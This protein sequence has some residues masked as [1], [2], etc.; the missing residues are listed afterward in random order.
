MVQVI[1]RLEDAGGAESKCIRF[2][3]YRSPREH[4]RVLAN[5]QNGV[6]EHGMASIGTSQLGVPVEIEFQRAF[7]EAAQY[8]V[9]F[10]WV[11]DPEGLFPPA[12]RPPIPVQPRCSRR[13]IVR[14]SA[15]CV[16]SRRR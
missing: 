14:C 1:E 9:P 12:Q 11:D 7:N 6:S 4:N 5:W 8:G 10:L 3:V 2:R 15:D 16:S 13:L